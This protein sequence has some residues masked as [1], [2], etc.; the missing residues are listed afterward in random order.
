MSGLERFL[1]AQQ[2]SYATALAELQAGEKRSHW[3]WYIFPQI[4][5]LGR[6]ETARHY[7]IRDIAEAWSYLA[8]PVLG[9]RLDRCTGAMLGWAGKR[10]AKAILGSLDAMKFHSSMTLFEAAR[11]GAR[12]G[13]AIDR[14]FMGAR[15]T[16]TLSILATA[17]A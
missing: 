12:F 14:F 10:G 16:D 5:G 13:E 6:S 4:A 11:G 7:A 17:E 15:D 2:S 8:H 1:D 9:P 3:M